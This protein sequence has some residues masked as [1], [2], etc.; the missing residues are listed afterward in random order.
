MLPD[1]LKDFPP[2][3]ALEAWDPAVVTGGKVHRGQFS[4]E[5]SPDRLL[6]A[7]R[8]LKQDQ[9]FVRLSGITGVDWFPVEPRFELIYL[10]HSIE[11]NRRLMLKCR[12]GGEN[13]EIDSV[14]DVWRSANW[15]EREI[16]DLFGVRFRNHPDLRRIMLPD[17]WEGHP[18]RKDY[19]KTGLK[20]TYR[21]E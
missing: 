21:S 7:C 5:V 3:A 13:P 10:L 1:A 6:E 9:R 12:L 16:F 17:E 19:P 8:F 2:A 20:Y 18:L 15:Y 14:L 11:H 4:V